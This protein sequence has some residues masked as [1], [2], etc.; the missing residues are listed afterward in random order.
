MHCV[1]FFASH[2]YI[3]YNINIDAYLIIV[4]RRKVS[5]FVYRFNDHTGPEDKEEMP[6]ITWGI[7]KI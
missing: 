1:L 2:I 4:K 7:E 6:Y 5:K 3:C